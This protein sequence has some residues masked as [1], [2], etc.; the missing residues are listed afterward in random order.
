MV[1]GL[2]S[3]LPLL[4][5]PGK[6]IQKIFRNF[7]FPGQT[8]YWKTHPSKFHEYLIPPMEF[9]KY[10]FLTKCLVL[11]EFSNNTA[12]DSCPPDSYG[13]SSDGIGFP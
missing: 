5:N 1:F 10:Y 9:V 13:M 6:L 3:F 11:D 2:V 12:C 8:N 7:S 4:T